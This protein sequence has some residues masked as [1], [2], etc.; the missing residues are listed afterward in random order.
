MS[1]KRNSEIECPRCGSNKEVVVWSSINVQLNLEAKEEL[2]EGKVN[3]FH[4]DI[5]CCEQVIPVDLLYHD[6]EKEFC[7]Q[8]FPFDKMVGVNP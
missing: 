3:L 8:F 2:L 7:V 5:C 6:M 4:C 1:I